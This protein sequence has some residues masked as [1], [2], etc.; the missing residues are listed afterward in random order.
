[1]EKRITTE[2][3]DDLQR[4]YSRDEVVI[5]MQQIGP[6]KSPGPDGFGA[7]FYQNYW[8][9]VGDEVT[10]AVL[11]FLRGKEGLSTLINQA[12]R[13]GVLNGVSVARGGIR[14]THMLFAYDCL[15]FGQ[16]SWHEWVK[17]KVLLHIYEEA[18]GQCLNRQKT[19]LFF[20][21]NIKADI[22]ER[23]RV[24]VGAGIQNNCEKYL[25]LPVMVGKSQYITF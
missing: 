23:I 6:L 10:E 25:G 7:S 4:E 8:E 13:R 18:S 15:V 5:A 17:I 2:M 16:A 22:R 19:A 24:D 3:N 1:M 12:E 14:V 11:S 9:V 20:S 21:S